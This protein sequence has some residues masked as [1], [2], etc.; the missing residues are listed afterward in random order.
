MTYDLDVYKMLCLFQSQFRPHIHSWQFHM[1][2]PN[3][4]H[5][6][7]IQGLLSHLMNGMNW[8]SFSL[9]VSVKHMPSFLFLFFFSF[10][11]I[12][13]TNAPR[14][15][16]VACLQRTLW[17]MFLKKQH[18]ILHWNTFVCCFFL[19]HFKEKEKFNGQI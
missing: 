6:H 2:C 1:E 12:H 3:M 17:I 8:N 18:I 9:V 10:L 19:F 11:D 14:K 5:F 15:G 13:E 4:I 16:L 7:F